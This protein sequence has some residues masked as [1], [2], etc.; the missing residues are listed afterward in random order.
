MGTFNGKLDLRIYLRN[1]YYDYGIYL[2]RDW[3]KLRL[4]MARRMGASSSVKSTIGVTRGAAFV[5][6]WCH[7]T[8]VSAT[9]FISIEPTCRLQIDY[10]LVDRHKMQCIIILHLPAGMPH[11]QSLSMFLCKI[12]LGQSFAVIFPCNSIVVPANCVDPNSV[13]I[14]NHSIFGI[15]RPYLKYS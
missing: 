14:W 3:M 7:R 4:S 9:R 8:P 12:V 6:S 11:Y 15:V 13:Y 1:Q 10:R 2:R 5:T